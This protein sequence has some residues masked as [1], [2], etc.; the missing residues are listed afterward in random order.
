MEAQIKKI[1]NLGNSPSKQSLGDK[2]ESLYN[3]NISA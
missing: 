3:A 1:N 2:V